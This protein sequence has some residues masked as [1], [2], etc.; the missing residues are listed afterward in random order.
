MTDQ[1][2]QWPI[3]RGT[4]PAHL[5]AEAVANLGGWVYEI[6]GSMVS[7]PDGYVPAEAILDHWLGW[8]PDTPAASV[9][10]QIQA[11]L[12]GHGNCPS[13]RRVPQHRDPPT[14]A[15][16][17]LVIGSGGSVG[18]ARSCLSRFGLA[19]VVA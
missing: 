13:T 14:A 11:T 12:A 19:G 10:G 6:D 3:E 18:T 7:N 8:L 9:R 17:V 15:G 1:G 4:M 16:E 2:P 5:A